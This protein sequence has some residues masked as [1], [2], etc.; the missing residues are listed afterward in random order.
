MNRQKVNASKNSA[1]RYLVGWIIVIFLRILSAFPYRII[2][3]FGQFIGKILFY[4]PSR[5]KVIVETN[6]KLCFPKLSQKEHQ[7]L[8]Y[9]H[10]QHAIRSFAERSIQWYGSAKKL[11]KLVLLES[12]I[13]LN[14]PNLPP[15]IFLGFHFVGIE[16]GSLFIN[17]MLQRQRACG[18]LYA[19]LS[20]PILDYQA[21]KQRSRF[22]AEMIN[23]Y[24]PNA[25]R[26]ALKMLKQGKPVMLGADMDF[27]QKDSVFAPFFGIP[28]ATLTAVGRLAKISQAQVVPF[29]CEVLPH[30]QGYRVVICSPWKNFPSNNAMAD[31][32]RMN[33]FLEEII[34]QMPEQYYWMHRRFKTRP[35]GQPSFYTK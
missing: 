18:S 12:K 22:N 2:A 20:N 26:R 19:P 1:L 7:S 29:F 23:K 15:T 25:I 4:I 31:A 9:Q 33:H 3:L 10:F 30:F 27:G 6:I 34:K 13:D 35:H 17:Y 32:T 16:A 24:S 14:N 8:A 21:Q 28:A 11:K 5:R